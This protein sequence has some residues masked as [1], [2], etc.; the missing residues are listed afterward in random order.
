MVG[1]GN[2]EEVSETNLTIK[3]EQAIKTIRDRLIKHGTY[4]DEKETRT[5]VLII[6]EIL[7]GLGWEVT[8]PEQ[9]Q[10]EIGDNGGQV[11]YVLL[12][13][14]RNYLAVV[15]AKRTKEELNGNR[16]RQAS[17]YATE[18]GIKFVILTNGA[19][20]ESWEINSGKARRKNIILEVNIATGGIEEIA[21]QMMAIH[22]EHL[23][24]NGRDSRG[25]KIT[26]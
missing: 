4:I 22:R 2:N 15:E 7:R 21:L 6:D 3:L 16:R 10:L 23:G 17:G 8:D 18:L 20:W 19:R 1:T 5:R 11:D 24:R 12:G 14:G 26:Y 9:V 25:A 13:K